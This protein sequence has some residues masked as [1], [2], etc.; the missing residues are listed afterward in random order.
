MASDSDW[1]R[2]ESQSFTIQDWLVYVVFRTVVALLQAMPIRRCERYSELLANLFTY[3]VRIRR[4]LVDSNLKLVFPLWSPSKSQEVQLGM[5]R[6][7]LLMVCEIAQAKRKIHR[8]N[9]YHFFSIVEQRRM[10][11]YAF[12]SRPIVMVSGHFGNFELAGYLTG[13][14]GVTSTT[15]A[16]PLDN[17]YVHNYVN[18]FRSISGQYFLPKTGSALAIQE[19]LDRGGSLGLLADQYGGPKGCWVDFLGHPASCHKGLA[20]FTLTSGAPMIVFSNLRLDAPLQFEM[21]V[22][23]IAD[24]NDKQNCPD[25]IQSLTRW[26]NEQLEQAIRA[27][28]DQYWWVHRRWRGEPP[29]RRM[30]SAA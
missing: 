4:S 10:L 16:R 28:P 21:R 26:Y 22:L 17:G 25:S 24:P 27:T 19:L 12:D 18:A 9:W 11:Q 7:L 14:F 13:L 8:E 2:P 30:A 29:R 1:D 3:H 15:I 5:W 20:L 6:H 23:G